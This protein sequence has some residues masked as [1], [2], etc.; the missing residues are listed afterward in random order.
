M[1]W[2][3]DEVDPVAVPAAAHG[4]GEDGDPAVTLLRV[5]VGDGGAGMDVASFVGDAGDIQ[6][7][8]GDGGLACP[9]GRGCPGCGQR[10]RGRRKDGAGQYARDRAFP[11]DQDQDGA[12]P[13]GTDFRMT[14]RKPGAPDG[15]AGRRV[16][17]RD[18]S[19]VPTT[20]AQPTPGNRR[21]QN[22]LVPRL[23]DGDSGVVTHGRLPS[24][25]AARCDE[26]QR[27]ASQNGSGL[28]PSAKPI[29]PSASARQR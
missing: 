1:T 4:R 15:R 11:G 24:F 22:H 28:V 9:R 26:Q 29:F 3:V 23:G 7:P 5:E 17:V 21:H 25:V 8:F 13:A 10:S 12:I 20:A 6:D 2:C 27:V 18:S 19:R 16:R 14:A